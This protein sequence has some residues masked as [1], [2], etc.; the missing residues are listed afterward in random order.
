MNDCY[1][2]KSLPTRTLKPSAHQ[3]LATLLPVRF[4]AAEGCHEEAGGVRVFACPRGPVR[5]GQVDLE[6]RLV[7]VCWDGD[8][9]RAGAV[10]D[11][12]AVRP[13][14]D[15]LQS[16]DAQ[17]RAAACQA[18]GQLGAQW[19]I[20]RLLRVASEDS[21]A[22]VR[23]MAAEAVARLDLPS[24][25]LEAVAAVELNI[26]CEQGSRA[27]CTMGP[28]R[29]DLRG[30]ALFSNVPTDAAC[31]LDLAS[32]PPTMSADGV[33]NRFTDL[34]EGLDFS[35]REPT[36]RSGGGCSVVVRPFPVEDRTRF[37]ASLRFSPPVQLSR[38]AGIPGIAACRGN[39]FWSPALVQA[40]TGLVWF[41]ALPR[42]DFVARLSV[43]WPGLAQHRSPLMGLTC[44]QRGRA[45]VQTAPMS[46][47]V[48]HPADQRLLALVES[49]RRG[50]VMLTVQTEC[51]ELV[52]SIVRY[53]L[54]EEC[55]E[56]AIVEAAGQGFARGSQ[57]LNQLFQG[58]EATRLA[59]Q[60][61][62]YEK[63]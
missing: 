38:G 29:T 45:L 46:P 14:L 51:P 54:G 41:N 32:P 10:E 13:L 34:L 44:G 47:Q 30:T 15:Q 52:N 20:Q 31:E 23:Q 55:G 21:S 49:D 53:T 24:V 17:G 40:A 56:I 39:Q 28:V 43:E 25:G 7:P 35:D 18:L 62:P 2:K 11:E 16:P 4:A 37:S 22:F 59:L 63:A 58:D 19:P 26:S 3:N 1:E 9:N 50:F 27:R 12:E 5:E 57:R 42:G 61:A 6:V 8:A 33:L 36:W 48:L 60:V